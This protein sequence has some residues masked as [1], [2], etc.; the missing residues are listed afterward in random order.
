M[1][2]IFL[3]KPQEADTVEKIAKERNVPFERFYNYCRLYTNNGSTRA[4]REA[5][6]ALANDGILPGGYRSI[7]DV[8]ITLGVMRSND[9]YATEGGI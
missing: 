2:N 7:K 9:I 3:Y 6:W 8:D 1:A 4:L 5:A